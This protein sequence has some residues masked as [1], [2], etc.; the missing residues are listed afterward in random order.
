MGTKIDTRQYVSVLR[1][2]TEQGEEASMLV[3]G[4][5]MAPFLVH[6]RDCFCFE[7]P[8]RELKKGDMVFFQRVS[9]EFIMHRIYKISKE[10]YFVVGD[11]QNYIEGPIK[12]EQIF[13]YVTKVQRKGKWI[14][15]GDFWWE[16]FE[17]VWIRVIPLRRVIRKVISKGKLQ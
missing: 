8:K 10:G 6:E 1:E 3:L 13:A 7:K 9:G 5:S 2:L 14:E 16:F 11:A 12:R 17:H 15:P 4:G